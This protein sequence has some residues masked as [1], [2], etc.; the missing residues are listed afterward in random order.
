MQKMTKSTQASA[1][2][3]FP[4]GCEWLWGSKALPCMNALHKALPCDAGWC[5]P[6]LRSVLKWVLAACSGR[7]WQSVS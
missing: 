3:Q 1:D 5:W 4:G 7:H 6:V 2:A